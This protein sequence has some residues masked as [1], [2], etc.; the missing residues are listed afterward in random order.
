MSQILKQSVG[1]D[2][3]KDKFDACFSVIDHQQKVTVKATRKFSNSKPGFKAFDEWVNRKA[4][5]QVSLVFVL[6]A[7][8]VY[9]EQLAWHLFEQQAQLS[10]VLPSQAKHYFKSVGLKS[11]NDKIDAK[12]LARMAAEQALD[13][14]Q[15]LS[16]DFYALRTLTRETERLH[17]GKTVL[18]NQRH[19]LQH[20][21]IQSKSSLR[22]IE[23]HIK[24]I[25][26]QLL[27]IEK[28]IEKTV[29]QNLELKQKIDHIM[30]VKGLGLMSIVTVLSECNGFAL[31]NNQKQL[32]SY[33]GYDIVERQSGTRQGKTRISKKGNSHIRRILHMPAFN[34]VKYEP[35]FTAF[36]NR[37]I[38][39]GK[40]KM[41]AYVA[42]QKKLLALIYTLWEKNEPFKDKPAVE[43][44]AVET[45]SSNEELKLLLP[46]VF[47]ENPNGRT[48][49]KKIA[50]TSRATQDELPCNVSLE[51]L[52]PV[53]QS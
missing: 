18:N 46:V 25:D 50:L 52:L 31:I 15:P 39:K 44:S 17:Q 9:Y 7:T 10:V 2:I 19:A 28:E 38:A 47:Q 27:A 11:K 51:V 29:S 5:L 33:A 13:R 26:K 23:Q 22:R 42:V 32:V 43:T 20:A 48:D 40:T 49:G 24:L 8:G 3:S 30:Q 34:V 35:R 37:L 4:A 45:T 12:G 1:I 53:E 16:S 41:Q 21:R 6:E 14:W 36:Y